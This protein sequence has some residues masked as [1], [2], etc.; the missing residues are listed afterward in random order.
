MS[1][2]LD[3]LL[4]GQKVEWKTLGDVSVLY[5]GLTGKNK[6][7]FENGNAKYVSY[8]NIFANLAVDLQN[9][10][11]VKANDNEKQHFIK[12]GDILFTGSSETQA[13]A[14]ISSVVTEHPIEKIYLN[15]FSFGLRFNDDV[16]L[17]PEFTKFLF[18]GDLMRT[19]IARTASGVT[20]FNISKE[21]FKKIQVPIPPLDVQAEIVRILDAFTA[22]TAELTQE[23]AKEKILREKQYQYYRDCL[24]TFENSTISEQRTANSEQRTANSMANNGS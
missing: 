14:G 1:A 7:D 12:H 21:R 24:L 15:S 10:G 3:K 19:Q 6:A 2:I 11:T 4:K 8:K 17:M 20:R 5:G 18:R 16:E 22:L 13:E 23:L 9:L